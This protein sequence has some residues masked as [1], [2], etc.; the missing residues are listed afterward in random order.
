LSEP[1]WIR[2]IDAIHL[3]TQQISL[4]GGSTGVRDLG[5]LQ[6]ALARPL[7]LWVYSDSR[8]S[9]PK[10]AATY[11][12]GISSNH[13]FLDG[14]KRTA[15]MVSFVFL[16]KNGLEVT[17]TQE[18]AFHTVLALAAG[19]LTEEQ[20]AAWFERNTAARNQAE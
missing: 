4:F 1:V 16:D 14:N 15:M 20:L 13:P 18:D 8:P 7:N 2:E 3:H 9:L 17:A 12:S 10:L 6:S 11:A 19:E 5:L